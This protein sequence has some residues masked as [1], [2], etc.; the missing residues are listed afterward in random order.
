M[1]HRHE[2]APPGLGVNTF[3]DPVA[4]TISHRASEAW[5]LLCRHGIANGAGSSTG[6]CDTYTYLRS[7]SHREFEIAHTRTHRY[8]VAAAAPRGQA[9]AGRRET[10]RGHRSHRRRVHDGCVRR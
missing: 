8:N 4:V 1:G 3:R 9:S 7:Q 6:T 10:R 5:P 2:I